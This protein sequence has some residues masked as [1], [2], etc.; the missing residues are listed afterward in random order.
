MKGLAR[1]KRLGAIVGNEYPNVKA[2]G[3]DYG[4]VL[5]IGSYWVHI[6]RFICGSCCPVLK[7]Q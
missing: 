6:F 2:H 7:T 1:T 5:V 4:L 3:S